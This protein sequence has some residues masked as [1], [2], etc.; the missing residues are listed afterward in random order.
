M[1]EMEFNCPESL[2]SMPKNDQGFYCQS[3]S[4]TIV[5]FTGKSNKEI[6]E[7]IQRNS[8]KT[9][10]VLRKNQV[11]NPFQSQI[12][13]LFR[14]AFSAVFV[15][16][17]SSANLFGQEEV[18]PPIVTKIKTDT[19][20]DVYYTVR[21]QVLDKETLEPVFF[22]KVKVMIDSTM[23]MAITNFDGF[24]RIKIL[25]N[26]AV[27]GRVSIETRSVMYGKLLIENVPFKSYSRMLN[28]DIELEQENGC[29]VGLLITPVHE[30]FRMDKDPY[31]FGKTV[32]KGDDLIRY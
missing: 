26:L 4:K 17:L 10:G 6:S 31:S 2:N 27:G 19:I 23:F 11:L 16:G 28:I 9:C 22:A 32:I 3:C 12:N 5:D 30:D 20:E 18:S 1:I 8:G 13:S 15:L 25:Q 29:I 7:I 14:L 21:G 24:Y